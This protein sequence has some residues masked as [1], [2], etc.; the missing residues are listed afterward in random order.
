[1]IKVNLVEVTNKKKI[2]EFPL[3]L[4]QPQTHTTV[5]IP[6]SILI[7]I[8]TDGWINSDGDMQSY[9]E[10]VVKEFN[11]LYYNID[12]SLYDI[13][14]IFVCRKLK[15]TKDKIRFVFGLGFIQAQ[16]IQGKQ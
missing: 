2:L 9:A 6:D 15:S 13:E 11:K 16:P 3:D 12:E 8:Q 10:T 4:L 5:A 7:A 1:M 14:Y